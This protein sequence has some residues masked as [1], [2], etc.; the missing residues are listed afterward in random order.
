M[1]YLETPG[2][3]IDVLQRRIASL[4]AAVEN[5]QASHHKSLARIDEL[6]RLQ[7][8]ASEVF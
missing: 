4:E 6:M 1:N 2:Q 7:A 5:L 8:E 3:E